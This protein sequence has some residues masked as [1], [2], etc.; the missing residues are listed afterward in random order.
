MILSVLVHHTSLMLSVRPINMTDG[1][2]I[3]AIDA[4]DHWSKCNA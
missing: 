2:A 4:F 3:L 1:S